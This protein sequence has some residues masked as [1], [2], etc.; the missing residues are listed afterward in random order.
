[1]VNFDGPPRLVGEFVDL[2]ITEALSHSLR[3]R[4]LLRGE[5][6]ADAA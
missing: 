4:V 5:E 6:S 3:G 1:M 2:V